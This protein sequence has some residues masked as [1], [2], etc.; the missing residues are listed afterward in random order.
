MAQHPTSSSGCTDHHHH[1]PGHV[2]NHAP[3]SLAENLD[4]IEFSRSVHAACIA[5]NSERVK[6]ILAKG[7]RGGVAPA[8]ALDSSGYTAL[9][10]ATLSLDLDHFLTI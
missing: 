8:D 6:A 1:Q 3:S 10:G 9:V 7:T 2:C 4:E 5:N